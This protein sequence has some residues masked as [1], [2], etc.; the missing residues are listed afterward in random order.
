MTDPVNNPSHYNQGGIETIEAIRSALGRDG[1]C[2]Y[3]C[4]NAMK[5]VWRWRHKGGIEDLKKAR[6]YL[7]RVIEELE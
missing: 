4:G 6:W 2:D 3:C 5:Y 1:F 7:D